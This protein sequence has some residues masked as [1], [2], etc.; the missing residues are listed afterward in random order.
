MTAKLFVAAAETDPNAVVPTVPALA[1]R[2]TDDEEFYYVRARSAEA[3]GYV[4]LEHPDI[5]TTPELL[6]DLRIGLS[7]DEP[8]VKEKLSKALEHVALG[9]PKRLAHHVSTLAEHLADEDELVRY[10][11]CTA[12]VIVGCESPEKLTEVSDTL[13]ARL[14]DEN[15]YVRGRAV[16]ALGVLARSDA[17]AVL[18]DELPQPN[19][20][21][22][23]FI[24]ERV[25]FALVD[26]GLGGDEQGETDEQIGTVP[27][28]RATTDEIVAEIMA[29]DGECP[30]C[31]LAL[32]ENGPPMC[33]RCGAPY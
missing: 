21:E 3:L 16:E 17:D 19:D 30:H 31:G 29:P 2:L 12:L 8:E 32:P 1:E 11:L 23:P 20:N 18:P 28:I 10:H 25:R 13:N 24:A 6:A 15:A 4:A 26:D 7:F 14:D 33:P 9:D 5:V 22:E 27:A